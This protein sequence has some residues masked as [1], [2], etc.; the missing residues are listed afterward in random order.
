[1]RMPRAFPIGLSRVFSSSNGAGDPPSSFISPAGSSVGSGATWGATFAR[2]RQVYTAVVRSA[3]TYGATAWKHPLEG[4]KGKL[5]PLLW[6]V[7]NRCLRT[8]AEPIKQRQS[9]A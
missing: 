3:I 6:T 9:E 2:S 1:M 4:I 5:T 8:V 7:Q